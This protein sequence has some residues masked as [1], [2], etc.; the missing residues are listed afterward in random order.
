MIKSDV[1]TH[2][3]ITEEQLRKLIE[4]LKKIEGFEFF[5]VT[6]FILKTT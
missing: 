4:G 3:N 2:E 6:P 1:K 5:V